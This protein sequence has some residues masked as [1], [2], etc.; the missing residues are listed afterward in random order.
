MELKAGTC[1]R[2]I[3]VGHV[4][5]SIG[6]TWPKLHPHSRCVVNLNKGHVKSFSGSYIPADK[7]V[8]DIDHYK[9][10]WLQATLHQ[11]ILLTLVIQSKY[12]MRLCFITDLFESVE[13][14]NY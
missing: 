7:D 4:F 1:P 8:T 2:I 13:P 11:D 14:I 6:P 9:I 3:Y 12:D 5:L 10:I